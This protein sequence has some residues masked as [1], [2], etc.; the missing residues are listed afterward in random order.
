MSSRIKKIGLPII[1]LILA[2]FIMLSLFSMRK[3][4]QQEVP[5]IK[6][7][8]VEITQA[9][10]QI[11]EH[12]LFSQGTVAP[13]LNAKLTA[14]VTAQ[15]AVLSPHFVEG[16]FVKKGTVLIQLDSSDFKT[17]LLAA[18]AQYAQAQALLEEELARA[19]VAEAEWSSIMDQATDLALRKPQ[20]KQQQANLRSAQAKLEKAQ[21][22]LERTE[23]KAPFDGIV[24]KRDVDIGQQVNSSSV[25]GEF[26]GTDVAEVRL[27]L[28]QQQALFIDIDK[29]NEKGEK[30]AVE[31]SYQT[32]KVA[33][34]WQA[35]LNRSEA[36]IDSGSRMFY[37]V[38]RIKDPYNLNNSHSHNLHF[39]R[40][41]D[42]KLTG[43]SQPDL[44][45]LPRDILIG[46]DQ[47]LVVDNDDKIE[48]RQVNVVRSDST[49]MY[50]DQGLS[51]GERVI[52][53]A[54]SSPVNGMLVRVAE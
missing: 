29:L 30:P 38:A 26:F 23:I 17:D 22:N 25:L 53:S 18:K 7:A 13:F 10:S 12:Q 31:L 41:V 24:V 49:H 52:T 11:I 40:F 8:L 1:I 4:Q 2:F 33:F 3:P 27:S 48:I 9:K 54:V 15:V 43:K 42:A 20:V 51:E 50:I 36:L 28:T 39:G 16:A 35:E 14:Q 32:N 6:P 34:T 47:I 21:R 44:F 46:T 45:V 37:V 5:E 19:D